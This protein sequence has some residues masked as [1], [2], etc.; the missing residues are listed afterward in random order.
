MALHF[1]PPSVKFRGYL[2]GY[3]WKHVEASTEHKKVPETLNVHV[4]SGNG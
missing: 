2:E 1:F 4:L 3:L